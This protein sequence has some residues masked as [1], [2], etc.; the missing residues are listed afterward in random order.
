MTL[1]NWT[2]ITN[3]E[4]LLA[5]PNTNTGGSFWATILWL[6]VIVMFISMLSFGFEIAVMTSCVIGFMAGFLLVYL[7]LVSWATPLIFMGLL[8]FMIIYTIWSNKK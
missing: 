2:N 4:G 1:V 7:G 5:I 6:I 8:L 3:P